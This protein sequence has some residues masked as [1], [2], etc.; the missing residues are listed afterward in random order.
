[1]R[2]LGNLAL[3]VSVGVFGALAITACATTTASSPSGTYFVREGMVEGVNLP[4]TAIWDMQVEVMDD[5]G[6]FDPDLMDADKWAAIKSHAAQLQIQ[7]ERMASAERYVAADPDGQLTEAPEGTDLVAIQGRLDANAQA[8]RAM[9][10]AFEGQ[11]AQLLLATQEQDA[12]K[13]TQ[14]VNDMQPVCKACH[15]VFWYPEEY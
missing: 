6:N 15:D 4:I 8:F 1:M 10:V 2:N 13:V 7:A 12:E 14:L 3:G 9:S 11:A 5:Y